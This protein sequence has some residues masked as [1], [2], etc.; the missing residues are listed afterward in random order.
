MYNSSSFF[1]ASRLRRAL[2]CGARYSLGPAR[3][4]PAW[5]AASPPP[6]TSLGQ[7]KTGL[8]DLKKR[9]LCALFALLLPSGLL[10][11]IMSDSVET[12]SVSAQ[13]KNEQTPFSKKEFSKIELEQ[14]SSRNLSNLLQKEA[15]IHIRSY[16]PGQLATLSSRGSGPEQNL[17][18]WEGFNLAN[19]ML[20][21]SDLNLIPLFF[22]DQL[23][24]QAGAGG[25]SV[26]QPLGGSLLMRSKSPRLAGWQAGFG[27]SLGSFS[28]QQQQFLLAFA[29]NNWR[30]SL[31]LLV[32]SA[33]NDYPY[34][35]L[36]AFGFPKPWK[37]REQAETA[38]QAALYTLDLPL[39]K[40]QLGLRSWLQKDL[41]ELPPTLLQ[42][43]QASS[44]V[45]N[46]LSWR[47]SLSWKKSF[48]RSVF[49]MRLG[50]L[51]QD[52]AYSRNLNSEEH[53]TQGI[54]VQAQQF[55]ALKNGALLVNGRWGR[56]LVQSSSYLDIKKEQQ[57][58]LSIGLRQPVL[59]AQLEGQLSLAHRSNLGIFPA[60]HLSFRKI[61]ATGLGLEASLQRSIRFPTLNDRFW[62]LVGQEDLQVEEGWQEELNIFWQHKIWGVHQLSLFNQEVEN[63]ILWLPNPNTALWEPQNLAAVW[64]RGASWSSEKTFNLKRLGQLQLQIGANYNRISRH[65]SP[66]A[67]LRD[68]QL[69]YRP[70]FS[71]NFGLNYQYK[72][73]RLGYHH[74]W[75]SPR[76]LDALNEE[77]LAAYQLGQIQL[78]WKG[79]MAQYPIR[80]QLQ[81]HNL[82]GTEYQLVSARPLPLQQW[83]LSLF[84]SAQ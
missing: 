56:N 21:Q 5:S 41:Q 38:R 44:E 16:G 28:R 11:Q 36:Q 2:R 3:A 69:E 62:P 48:S 83:E 52:M 17:L 8:N 13:Q 20:G 42:A 25:L 14:E 77:A 24:W 63:W 33:V 12:V 67:D 43:Q 6:C 15:G 64:A 30:Q 60:G 57:S 29:K 68:K 34:R 55:F 4:L 47:N 54:F 71:A 40:G 46:T 73:W 79:Q 37:R 81:V 1:G 23:S 26:P 84:F 50:Y 80:L 10:A 53:L 27:S 45:Q 22:I 49:Q 35:D 31:R 7:K 66:S 18:R 70:I 65:K 82:W 19:P 72:A 39:F 59:G 9:A 75:D 58:R 51:Y 74:L 78:G 61:W 76:Y 32:Q